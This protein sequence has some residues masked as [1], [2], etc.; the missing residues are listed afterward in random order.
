MDKASIETW[1]LERRH[2]SNQSKDSAVF[3]V[4]MR[5][6]APKAV[7]SLL[8]KPILVRSSLWVPAR[9]AN[10]GNLVR[11]ENALTKRIL[12]VTLMERATG[13]KSHTGKEMKRILAKD[14]SKL[15]ALLP[16][17]VF[18]IAED[19]N[20]KLCTKETEIL[21]LFYGKDTYRGN[22][23]RRTLFVEG[24]IFAQHNLL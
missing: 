11:R 13:C 3:I 22:C 18:V 9:R 14:G 8:E 19:N 24:P 20:S 4:P 16:H 17:L 15:L 5:C 1:I 2:E 7:Q 10:N 23:P 6:A 21:I 12:T